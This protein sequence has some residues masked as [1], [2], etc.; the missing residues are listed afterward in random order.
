LDW[1]DDFLERFGSAKELD[2]NDPARFP[3]GGNDYM[4]MSSDPDE[5]PEPPKL[6]N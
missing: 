3:V 2:R 5:L 6:N 4:E 1:I